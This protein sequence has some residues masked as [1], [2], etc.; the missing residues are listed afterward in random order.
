[1]SNFASRSW[2]NSDVI[3]N[4]HTHTNCTTHLHTLHNTCEP[5]HIYFCNVQE[6]MSLLRF[7]WTDMD[8]KPSEATTYNT[9]III[10][11]NSKT[12]DLKCTVKGA[13]LWFTYTVILKGFWSSSI[14]L[15]STLYGIKRLQ[16]LTTVEAIMD[17]RTTNTQKEKWILHITQ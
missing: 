1:M 7:H 9:S 11:S 13:F 17:W 10:W 6:N 8:T 2:E 4:I 15:L 3:T 14:K 12:G 16:E 5:T